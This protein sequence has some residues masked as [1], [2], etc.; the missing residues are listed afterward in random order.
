MTQ[1]SPQ[2][3]LIAKLSTR[4]AL[5]SDDEVAIRRLTCSIRTFEP[6]A[7]LV[8]EGDQPLKCGLVLEGFAF[9][10]KAERNGSRQIVALIVPGD[11]S[12]IQQFALR[13]ADHGVQ[14]LTQIRL[15]EIPSA[16]LE[17]MAVHRPNVARAL[18]IETLV[19]ASITREALLNNGRRNAASRIA[20][21]LCEL[22][23]RLAATGRSD[24]GY[25]LPMTQE[26]LAD[27]TGLTAVH[28]NRTL[29][30]LG[31]QGLIERQARTIKIIDWNRL[32]Q[33]AD[34][35]PDYLHLDQIKPGR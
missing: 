25:H 28:V 9:R 3:S 12:D 33:F 26:Q 23:V 32:Q 13:T 22:E 4:H 5:D 34:F 27:A 19:E 29:K 14:A 7:D 18:W 21:F 11:F 2:G 8:R 17:E 6:G 1:T 15:A 31:E 24:R 35:K 30:A 20:H 16:E 10:H